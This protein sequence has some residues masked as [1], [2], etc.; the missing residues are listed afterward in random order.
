MILNPH[1][2]RKEAVGK[3]LRANKPLHGTWDEPVQDGDKIVLNGTVAAVLIKVK[4]RTE[5]SFDA[6]GKISQLKIQR[7]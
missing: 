7:A 3:F 1:N 5:F 6:S 2:V 4:L